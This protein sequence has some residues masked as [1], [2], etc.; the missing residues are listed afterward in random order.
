MRDPDHVILRRAL[1]VA[2]LVP[3][4][5]FLTQAVLGW[6]NAALGSAF[7]CFTALAFADFGGP[8]KQR[9]TANLLL[10]LNG[11]ILVSVAS[12]VAQWQPVLI[13]CTAIIV[14]VI[15]YSAVLR[16]YFAAATSAAILPWVFAATSPVDPSVGFERSAGW[17]VGALVASIGSVVLWPM[18]VRSNL[19][20]QLADVLDAAAELF[21]RIDRPDEIDDAY[22]RFEQART[23]LRASY[24]G[25][26][27]RPGA[28]TVRD[29]SLMQAIEEAE[30]LGTRFAFAR[31]SD[32]GLAP[33]DHRLAFA[34]AETLA[35]CAEA[36]RTGTVIPDARAI[37]DARTSHEQQ[38]V[39]WCE[40]KFTVGQTEVIRPGVE[41]S[42]AV[43]FL[44][45]TT[46]TMAIYVAGAMDPARD[47]AAKQRKLARDRDRQATVR[48]FGK[49]IIEPERT[50]TPAAMLRRQFTLRSPWFRTAIRTSVAITVTVY[51]VGVL[52]AEHGFWAALGALVALKFDASGTQR[53]AWQLLL[54]TLLGFG[55]GCA[56]VLAIGPNSM[57]MWLVLPIA[58][59]LAAYT[60]GAVSFIIG[61][62][63][64]TVFVIVLLGIT[65]PGTIA[66]AE[67][68]VADVLIGI[69][70]GLAVSLLMWPHGV[71]PMVYR[72]ARDAIYVATSFVM[73]RYELLVDGPLSPNRETALAARAEETA[74]RAREAFDLAYSQQ[75][76]GLPRRPALVSTINMAT[77]LNYTAEV[78]GG[79]ATV[80]SIPD[81]W[82]ASGDSLLAAAHRVGTR[83][84][85]LVNAIGDPA[86][87]SQELFAVAHHRDSL[88]RL[89]QTI[90]A[91]LAETHRQLDAASARAIEAAA[92]AASASAGASAGVD[93]D[94][95]TGT[96]ARARA[97]SSSSAGADTEPA[98]DSSARADLDPRVAGSACAD[99]VPEGAV[100]PSQ[101]GAADE[102][103]VAEAYARAG[104]MAMVLVLALVWVA[105]SAWLA[106]RLEA[107]ISDLAPNSHPAA[108][109][110]KQ[111]A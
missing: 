110:A 37:D 47:L 102:Q 44:A 14:F 57:P 98:V 109:Q 86:I 87:T 82:G 101:L 89:R 12:W 21:R 92:S 79:L 24:D 50:I 6:S 103:A 58:A 43:R 22:K 28:G 17:A 81:E 61:Q 72:T 11:V 15:A 96:N 54:G 69:I 68:R 51:I 99:G 27:I 5:Y 66:T 34:S 75:G 85:A 105:E 70:V 88:V 25:K 65:T 7:A 9:L 1:R 90:D 95:D 91:D 19:R 20:L 84:V 36:L 30:R 38:L 31:D 53:T 55:V 8:R 76:P 3:S 26:L 106:D 64:F 78:V 13:A 33:I 62:A 60:P 32:P 77:E 18:Y 39:N 10:G 46:Q 93:T 45:L 40:A 48:F 63:S 108:K 111:P 2:V 80:G 83:I 56:L 94:R 4:T 74:S 67:W 107:V 29:R 73:V 71:V 97:E 104:R 59:F 42:A 52:G 41:E 49:A 16:G 35:Q 23:K 100:I